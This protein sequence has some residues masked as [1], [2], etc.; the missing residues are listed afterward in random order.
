MYGC[1]RFTPST[2][3]SPGRPRVLPPVIAQMLLLTIMKF[4]LIARRFASRRRTK[5]IEPSVHAF[6]SAC[7]HW[8]Q[9]ELRP[10]Q[11]RIRE[12]YASCDAWAWGSR[13]EGF[14]LPI[15]EAMA[16]RTPVVATPAGAAP[17]LLAKGGGILVAHEDPSAMSDALVSLAMGDAQEWR[18]YSE[19]AHETAVDN[20]CDKAAE[21]FEGALARAIDR[22]RVPHSRGAAAS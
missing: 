7:D 6:F 19:A 13:I 8:V 22:G 17:S 9:F 1:S 4:G 5:S 18:R 2:Y 11:A 10:A 14:G 3:F 12:I 16:C 21:R 15:L 20:T